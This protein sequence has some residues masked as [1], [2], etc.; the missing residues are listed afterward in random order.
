[1][2]ER[3]AAIR[4]AS[5]LIIENGRI[6]LI[7]EGDGATN[8]GLYSVPGGRCE[9]GE[10]PEA[11]AVREAMEEINAVVAINREINNFRTR[12]RGNCLHGYVY[13]SRI[14]CGSPYPGG[15]VKAIR[16]ADLVQ[17]EELEACGLMITGKLFEALKDILISSM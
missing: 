17:I 10:G 5:S 2:T 6:L 7:L 11:C 16:W 9:N 1:M 3:F 8:S 13:D 14:V 4:T 12:V 15:G